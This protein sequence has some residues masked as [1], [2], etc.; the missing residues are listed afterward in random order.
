MVHLDKIWNY[1]SMYNHPKNRLP[2]LP[3]L[4]KEKEKIRKL[5]IV[6]AFLFYKQ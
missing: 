3:I 1:P 5:L 4:K 2:M 6:G